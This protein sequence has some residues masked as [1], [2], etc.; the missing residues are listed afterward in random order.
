MKKKLYRSRNDK[1]IGGVA[2]GLGDYFDIDVTLI[3][4]IFIV[5]LV[6]GG[7]GILAY[8]ILWIVVPEEPYPDNASATSNSQE[9]STESKDEGSTRMHKE[10]EPRRNNL[11]GVILIVLGFIFLGR[12]FIP[13]FH[14]GDFWPIILIVIGIS[15]LLRSNSK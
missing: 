6:V 7:S 8:I 2:G 3:R 10:R 15:L 1:M 14:F 4:I 5:A 13:W 12:N 9:N 11:G